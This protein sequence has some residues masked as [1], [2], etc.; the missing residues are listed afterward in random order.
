MHLYLA[1]VVA[2]LV[3]DFLALEK[4]KAVMVQLIGAPL[5]DTIVVGAFILGVVAIHSRLAHDILKCW[6]H[7]NSAQLR[8]G[9]RRAKRPSRGNDPE[10]GAAIGGVQ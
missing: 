9:S 3:A 10:G 6:R 2:V 4:L 8:A 7:G 5:Q 1:L